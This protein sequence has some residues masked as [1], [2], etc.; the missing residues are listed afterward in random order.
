VQHAQELVIALPPDAAIAA[1][2][3]VELGT[4]HVRESIL[5]GREACGGAKLVKHFEQL[6]AI[7]ARRAQPWAPQGLEVQAG[8]AQIVL[9]LPQRP[10]RQL[11]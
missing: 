11:Q 10:R 5:Q 2:E 6:L 9:P 3:V 1:Q 8:T 7:G 4:R